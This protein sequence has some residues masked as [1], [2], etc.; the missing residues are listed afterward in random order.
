MS[1]ASSHHLHRAQSPPRTP[2]NSD[3]RSRARVYSHVDDVSWHSITKDTWFPGI[4]NDYSSTF[5]SPDPEER[6]CTPVERCF[7]AQRQRGCERGRALFRDDDDDDHSRTH[8]VSPPSFVQPGPPLILKQDARERLR[9]RFFCPAR[10]DSPTPSEDTLVRLN[11]QD[12]DDDDDDDE[13]ED[14]ATATASTTPLAGAGGRSLSATPDTTR[15]SGVHPHAH[16][17]AHRH[18]HSR[19]PSVRPKNPSPPASVVTEEEEG[20]ATFRGSVAPLPPWAPPRLTV[21]PLPRRREASARQATPRAVVRPK[22]PAAVG[23]PPA[24]NTSND[25]SARTVVRHPVRQKKPSGPTAY[26]VVRSANAAA[27]TAPRR[28]PTAPPALPFYPREMMMMPE[29]SLAEGGREPWEPGLP[30]I[31]DFLSNERVLSRGGVRY[32]NRC[33]REWYVG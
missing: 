19:V 24:A 3:R 33:P 21:P 17:H 26:H 31:A 15:S 14:G 18:P 2:T 1:R 29:A 5:S 30:Y 4:G 8:D 7:R 22:A 28:I 13:D 25:S 9:A 20:E 11:L 10:C 32:Q 27:A 6:Q 12:D 23:P 16:A